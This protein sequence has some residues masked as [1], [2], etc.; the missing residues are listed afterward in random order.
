MLETE[1]QNRIGRYTSPLSIAPYKPSPETMETGERFMRGASG[2]GKSIGQAVMEPG[3]LFVK[4]QLEKMG[5]IAKFVAPLVG[6]GFD[7]PIPRS[8]KPTTK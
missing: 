7:A 4:P 5:G 6:L 1:K 8:I 3:T 2:I